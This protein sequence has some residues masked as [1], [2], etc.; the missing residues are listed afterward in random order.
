MNERSPALEK[1]KRMLP[2]IHIVRAA[3]I[4]AV[5]IVHATSQTVMDLGKTTTLYPFYNFMNI[6]FKFG[7][8]TFIFLSSF[9]LFYNYV[10]RRE[11][12]GLIRRFYRRRLKYVVLPYVFFSVVYFAVSAWM[13]PVD[14]SWLEQVNAFFVQ[15]ATGKAHAHLYFVFVSIQFYMLF[16]FLL[17][18]VWRKPRLLKH[19]LW[20]GVLLQWAFVLANH[21]F[22]QV[23]NKGSIA[24]SYVSFYFAGAWMGVYFREFIHWMNRGW[25]YLIAVVWFAFG[26]LHVHAYHQL[27]VAEAAFDTKWF[28]FVWHIHALSSALLLFHLGFRLYDKLSV[29]QPAEAATSWFHRWSK[30]FIRIGMLSFGIY[31]IHPLILMLY[32]PF[33][34]T[35]S[36]ALYHIMVACGGVI[37]LA[38]SAGLVHAAFKYWKGAWIVFGQRPALVRDKGMGTG[39]EKI[40]YMI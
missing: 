34:I 22:W 9:V 28:E 16:P 31:L 13:Y 25:K 14:E 1:K 33:I 2:E 18:A 11:T 19:A 15:L 7:T 24:L 38:L 27:R 20:A 23:E 39:D 21:Y 6:F 29:D 35:S 12:R 4:V 32:R 30:P 3:A 36:A 26:S 5:L 10:D 40:N 8:P 17:Y 37:A